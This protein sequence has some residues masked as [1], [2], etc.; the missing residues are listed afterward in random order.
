[1]RCL[2][3]S[4]VAHATFSLKRS[5]GRFLPLGK[6]EPTLKDGQPVAVQINVEV[7]FRLY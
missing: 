1:M 7:S 6:F 2:T 3:E 4:K 5:A